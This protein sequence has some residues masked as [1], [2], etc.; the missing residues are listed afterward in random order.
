M[1]ESL[2]SMDLGRKGQG[3]ALETVVK[4][5]ILIITVIVIVAMIYTFSDQI[6]TQ[7]TSFINSVMGNK[8]STNQFPDKPIEKSSFSAGDIGRYI[9]SCYTIMNS[10]DPIDR[11]DTTCYI[12]VSSNFDSNGILSNVP[13]SIQSSVDIT[14][15]F[16]KGIV[17]IEYDA[18]YN[19]VTV[20]D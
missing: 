14:T 16:N 3:M 15:K 11:K 7:V 5:L 13:S 20:R 4:V 8:P 10:V 9:E 1:A 6:R 12:L 19:K 2:M 17:I 18:L